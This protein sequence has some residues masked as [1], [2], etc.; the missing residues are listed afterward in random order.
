VPRQRSPNRDKAFEIYKEHNGNIKL[1]DIAEQLNVS[2]VQ[3][4]KWKNQDKWNDNL[5]GTLPKTN[6]NVT[7][8]KVTKKNINK[9]VIADKV[10]EVLENTELTDK[11]RLF[12]SYY[13]KYRNKTKAYMKA[14]K[15]SWENANAHAYELWENVGVKKEIDRRLKELR[16]EL[17]LEAQ[18]LVQKYIDI[19]FADINDYLTFGRKKVEISKDKNDKPVMIE[20]NYVDFK[21]SHEVDGTIIS[22]VKQGRDGVSIKLQDKMKAMDWLANHIDLLDTATKQKLK[23]EE[24]KLKMAREKLELEKGQANLNNDDTEL[25][26]IVDYG[27]ENDSS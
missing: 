23:N 7:N 3:I 6:S 8:K 17:K 1:I 5:K 9:E 25:K 22:E 26:I 19:A 10:K 4:R 16:D 27:D 14:Y 18:D 20:V 2:D 12:C 13:V 21:N 11:Q 24:E 15:C